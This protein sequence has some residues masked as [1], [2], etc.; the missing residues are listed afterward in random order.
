MVSFGGSLGLPGSLHGLKCTF[1]Q[2]GMQGLAISAKRTLT[3][4]ALQ[5]SSVRRRH[6]VTAKV[7][8]LARLFRYHNR[9]RICLRH[10]KAN[11]QWQNLTVRIIPQRPGLSGGYSVSGR[12]VRDCTLL[13]HAQ[14]S[15]FG[16]I[17]LCMAAALV[18]NLVTLAKDVNVHGRNAGKD[19]C[20][21][22]ITITSVNASWNLL[23]V[24][25]NTSQPNLELGNLFEVID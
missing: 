22:T 2:K 1:N 24:L 8:A 21:L 10:R 11:M 4:K 12:V 6:T 14:F 3:D 23:R 19:T 15:G 13:Y 25:L 7:I 17:G 9:Q 18:Y 20:T 5:W 16:L